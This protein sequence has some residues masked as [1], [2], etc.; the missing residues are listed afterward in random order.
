M[1]TYGVKILKSR[2]GRVEFCGLQIAQVSSP[3]GTGRGFRRNGCRL[4]SHEAVHRSTSLPSSL[5]LSTINIA[6]HGTTHSMHICIVFQ[7]YIS[8]N[9]MVLEVLNRKCV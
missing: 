4:K 3:T 1:L 9:G 5:K 7:L 2:S 6:I 8:A